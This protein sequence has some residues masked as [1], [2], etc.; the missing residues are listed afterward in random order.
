MKIWLLSVFLGTASLV[1][2]AGDR[3]F[4]IGDAGAER[5]N[6]VHELSDGTFLIAGQ[7]QSL[8][9]IPSNVPRTTLNAGSIASTSPGNV[10]FILHLNHDLST[11][12]D[13][14]AFPAGSVRDVYRIRSTEVPGQSTGTIYLSG[15]CDGSSPGY[16]IAKL[17][18]NWVHA[19]PTQLAWSYNVASAAGSA[20]QLLQPWDVDGNGEVVFGSGL[21]Y[22]Y[23]WAIV[24]RLSAGG[25]PMVV[26]HW[27]AHW[28]HNAISNQDTEWDGTPASSY[29]GT[30]ALSYSGLVLK[31]GRKGSLRS[32]TQADFDVRQDDGNG[33]G[34]RK[35]R[36]PDDYYF[37]GPCGL[38]SG[39]ACSGGPG[40]TGYSVA[41]PT[42]RLGGVAIDRRNGRLYVGYSTQTTSTDGPDFEPAIVAMSRDGALLWWNRLYQETSARSTP[43]QYVDGMA[44]DY[45]KDEI[46]VL[47]R[48]HGNNTNNLW[49]GQA[50]A[51]RPGRVGFQQQFT[52]NNGNIH[53]SWLGKF[54]LASNEL[55]AATYIAEFNEGPNNY[56]STFVDPL[57]NGWPNPNTGWP[58]LNTTRNCNDMD[59]GTDGSVAVICQGRRSLTTHGAHQE[60]PS[61]AGPTSSLV[62]TWNFFAR[63]YTPD[64]A[65]VRYSSLLTGAWD[66]AT[67]AGGDNTQWFG[68]R[69][70]SSSLIVAGTHLACTAVG[71]S[72]TDALVASGA[73]KPNPTPTSAVPAWGS[74]LPSGKSGLLGRLEFA[75]TD[76]IFAWGFEVQ[77]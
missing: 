75:A 72:C 61:P 45:A 44:I 35:G 49:Q 58:N 55:H 73:A 24:E 57:L 59:I 22:D 34:D 51:A 62:G 42:Q 15:S 66:T 41:R 5:V 12:L 76:E 30:S 6:D 14:V 52:G 70:S 1:A 28:S 26:N 46:V 68:V 20:Y 21:E 32:S 3:F 67:G 63:V 38:S 9:W 8:A 43:D 2:N 64:L 13:V 11:P 36:Y 40:Y 29:S 54:A 31:A 53:V 56:G 23:N 19:P 39:S 33:H 60:M 65:S 25:Q 48:A 37:S 4:Y 47:A 77:P 50:I 16:Y 74:S 17:D 18:D 10:G 69:F 71:G 7:A 27:S